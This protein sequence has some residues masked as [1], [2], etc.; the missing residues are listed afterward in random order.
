MSYFVTWEECIIITIVPSKETEWNERKFYVDEF[1]VHTKIS[2]RIIL[3]FLLFT[4]ITINLNMPLKQ[5]WYWLK[6][7]KGMFCHNMIR[8]LHFFCVVESDIQGSL[9]RRVSISLSNLEMWLEELWCY[10]FRMFLYLY[11]FFMCC[12]IFV[13]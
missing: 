5:T 3:Q 8:Y 1:I 9:L 13:F 7:S 2:I 11:V 10:S 4:W 12:Y 6:R